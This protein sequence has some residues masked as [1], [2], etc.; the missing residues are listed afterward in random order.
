LSLKLKA[1][2]PSKDHMKKL[3]YLVAAFAGL[4]AVARTTFGFETA[5]SVNATPITAVPFIITAPGNYFLPADLNVPSG[6]GITVNAN[7]VVIDLNGRSLNSTGGSIAINVTNHDEVTIQNGDIDGFSTANKYGILLNGSA[8]GQNQ[9]N[10]V[11]N[12]NFDNDWIGV[13]LVRGSIDEV[14][15]CNFDGGVYGIYDVASDGGDRFQADNSQNQTFGIVSVSSP[16]AGNLIEDCL[17][18]NEAAAG[19]FAANGGDRSRFNT[20]V[21]GTLKIGGIILGF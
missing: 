6:T 21:N 12:V 14:E 18:A 5:Q 7:Q 10:L 19:I 4:L 13:L 15:H 2:K 1:D 20:A 11:K 8:N 9:K 3:L 16:T 17:F